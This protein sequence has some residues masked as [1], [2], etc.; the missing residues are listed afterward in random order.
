MENVW[1]VAAT[2][3][4]AAAIGYMTNYL[5]IKMLFLPRR[6][7]I[8]GGRRV[9]FTPGL[10]PKRKG[11]IAAALG[12]VVSEYLVTTEGLKSMLQRP[13]LRAQAEQ[14]L[15][16]WVED[17]ACREES[18]EE[19][20]TRRFGTEAAEELKQ[21]VQQAASHLL[22]QGVRTLI[23]HGGAGEVPGGRSSLMRRPLA[24]L[25]AELEIPAE[26]WLARQ[27][28]PRLMRMLREQLSGPEGMR[29][30]RRLVNRMLEGLGGMMGMLAGM[31]L[32]EDKITAKVRQALLA[33][34]NS[35]EAQ[36]VVLRIAEGQLRQLSE[37]TPAELLGMLREQLVQTA[38][39]GEVGEG[40]QDTL[41]EAEVSA[42]ETMRQGSGE[43][44]SR[45]QH[46]SSPESALE[47]K[48]SFDADW[49]VKVIEGLVPLKT[50]LEHFWQMSPRSLLQNHKAQ[51]L[52]L[53]PAVSNAFIEAAVNHIEQA[54][55]ALNLPQMVQKQVEDFPMDKV[56]RVILSITGSEFRAITWLG[57]LLGG[58]I[59]IIQALMLVWAG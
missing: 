31:F 41:H 45:A 32:D 24:E 19:L 14:K 58:M 36:E 47:A 37:R 21:K 22:S 29:L 20:V 55:Q 9:P 17:M 35:R 52:D 30:I 57:A 43:A 16:A 6:P 40:W 12:Q 33:Y 25:F 27:G 13:E 38:S 42:D 53:V 51:L 7:W 48:G 28:V 4:I 50:W 5:A 2:I 56:E 23:E 15:R 1:Y 11:E 26:T 18:L 8:I 49:L 59:G 54:V 44:L 39:S 10:I 46:G 34:L 3:L